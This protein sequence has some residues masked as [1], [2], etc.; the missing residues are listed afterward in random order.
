MVAKYEAISEKQMMPFL[1]VTCDVAPSPDL[2]LQEGNKR[3]LM[4]SEC[5][6]LSEQYK[7]EAV[8]KKGGKK[9]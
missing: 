8:E 2:V 5:P 3:H 9:H 7:D 1:I 4:M 6:L